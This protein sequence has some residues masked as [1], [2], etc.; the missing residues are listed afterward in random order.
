MAADSTAYDAVLLEVATSDQL[1][2]QIYQ[3]NP[4][5]EG[6]EKIEPAI[7]IGDKAITAVHTGRSGGYSAV[8]RSGSTALNAAGNQ[9]QS[10]AQW[11]WTHH[12]FQIKIETATVDETNNK[13]KAIANVVT[14]EVDGAVN[15]TRRQL[16]RQAFTNGD[17]LIA[18]TT[19]TATSATIALDATDYGYDAIVRGWLYP[20]LTVDIGTTAN[21]VS[22]VA[23]AVIS[24]VD[25]TAAAPTIT[26]DSSV[27]LSG[28]T[29]V[30]VANARSGT[31][32]NETN[33]LRNLIGS[34]TSIVGTL[35]PST[36]P[37]WKPAAVDSTTTVLSLPSLYASQ[38]AVFQKS[39]DEPDWALTSP[40]QY[41]NLYS[42]LQGQVRFNGD[43]NL[44]AGNM[45]GLKIGKTLVQ[46]QPD[47]PKRDFFF[48]TKGDLFTVRTEGPEWAP[49][50]YGGRGGILEW[51]QGTTK[52]VSA[53]VYR[54]QLGMK[55][56]NRASALTALT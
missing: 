33:G 44:G 31:T 14:A 17:A 42:L 43:G 4:L 51:Q 1:E 24:S 12:W 32:S 10:Q 55:R 36:V 41:Q 40:D 9:T 38:K 54:Y 34:T 48:L 53:L 23:D 3:G 28:T 39:G 52:L 20:G 35:N 13:A 5:L 25:E 19:G 11:N 8:P 18:K 27:T 15:D 47:C 29:Y 30:S 26:I 50:K 37:V 2:E 7:Q 46:R 56:R 21:E 6:L 22:I 45:E 16:T 49:K